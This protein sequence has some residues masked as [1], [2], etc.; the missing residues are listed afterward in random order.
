M[1]CVVVCESD[2]PLALPTCPVVERR[3]MKA[4]AAGWYGF[5]VFHATTASSVAVTQLPWRSQRSQTP[6]MPSTTASHID[7]H[8]MCSHK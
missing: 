3:L 8:A 5:G 1:V 6:P 4:T 7:L 2:V